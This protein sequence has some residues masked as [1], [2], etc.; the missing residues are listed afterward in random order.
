MRLVIP[1]RKREELP[2]EFAYPLWPERI[3]RYLQ[4]TPQREDAELV[5]Q[6][7]DEFWE[8]HWRQRIEQHGTIKLISAIYTVNWSPYYPK[9]TIEVYSVPKEYLTAAQEILLD[10][11]M[12]ALAEKLI[13]HGLTPEVD[14]KESIKMNLAD[15]DHDESRLSEEQLASP[16]PDHDSGVAA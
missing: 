2:D 1:T 16:H 3:T 12:E 13:D 10:G 7:R 9:W 6:W 15:W 8:S 5:F 4:D 14:T 11:A